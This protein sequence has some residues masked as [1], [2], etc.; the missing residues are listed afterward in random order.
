MWQET[1]MQKAVK[2]AAKGK[3][4]RVAVPDGDDGYRLI[5]F[6]RYFQDCRFLIGVPAVR[7]PEFEEAMRPLEHVPAAW[8]DKPAA[9]DAARRVRKVDRGKVL[10]LHQAGRSNKWIADDMGL[11]E[12]TVCRVLREMKG[13]QKHEV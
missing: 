13:E 7:N 9:P 3:E 1:D 5:P 10:A 8:E 2:A 12:G 6:E 11:H 4:V